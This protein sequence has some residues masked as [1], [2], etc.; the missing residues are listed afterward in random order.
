MESSNAGSASAP[1]MRQMLQN[2]MLM[3][4]V[5][6]AVSAASYFVFGLFMLL[7]R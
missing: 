4:T 5:L 6:I 3:L 7:G 2:K 1:F